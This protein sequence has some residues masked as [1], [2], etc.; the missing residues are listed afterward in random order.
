MYD[1]LSKNIA[2]ITTLG[3]IGFWGISLT[4]EHNYIEY[5]WHHLKWSQKPLILDTFSS[6]MAEYKF[7]VLNRL[8]IA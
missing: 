6:I 2:N 3:F 4:S 8:D 5:A 1:Q 7:F